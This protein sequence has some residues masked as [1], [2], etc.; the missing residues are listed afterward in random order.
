MAL[1]G[2]IPRLGYRELKKERLEKDGPPTAPVIHQ[3]HPEDVVFRVVDGNPLAQFGC[4]SSD[5]E[6]H[7][8]FDVQQLRWPVGRLVLSLWLGLAAWPADRSAG[9]DDGRGAAVVADGKTL[10]R[11]IFSGYILGFLPVGHEGILLSSEHNPDIC[12]VVDGRVKVRVIT[13]NGSFYLF[14]YDKCTNLS[15]EMHGSHGLG[16]DGLVPEGDILPQGRGLGRE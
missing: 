8:Q 9:D 15:R 7:L 4:R 5:E 14:I 11:R 3:H 6:G 10:P 13:W 2:R 12:R 1:G 16:N